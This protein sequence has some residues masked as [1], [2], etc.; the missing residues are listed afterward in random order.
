MFELN[1]VNDPTRPY[2]V[3]CLGA[4][5]DDIEIG[6]GGTLLQLAQTV[7]NLGIDWVIFSSTPQRAQEARDSANAFLRNVPDHTVTIHDFRDG[8]FPSLHTEL[9]ERFEQLKLQCSP[10]VI[11]THYREDLHQDHKMIS[12]LTWNTFRRHLIFEYE[13]PKYDGDFGIPNTFVPVSDSVCQDKVR[14]LME[15][16]ASQRDKS[17][18]CPELFSAVMRLRGME[19]NAASRYA[20]AFYCRKMRLCIST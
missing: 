18:F 17:W 8:F 20:E 16:Y 12:E 19:A 3:L 9:K 2:R 7:K 14:Y 13:I 1:L 15:C 6:C 10:D 5:C 4:H 11:F